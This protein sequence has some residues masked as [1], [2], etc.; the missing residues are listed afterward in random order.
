MTIRHSFLS[1]AL[2]LC[3]SSAWGQ[4]YVISTYAGNGTA[5]FTGDGGAPTSAQLNLPVGLTFDSSGNLYI[6]DGGNYRVR[7]IS[8]GSITTVAGNGTSGYSGDKAGATS[9]ELRDPT[10]LALDS[11]GNLYIADAPNHVIRMVTPG[12]TITTFAGNNTGG[13]AGDG[14][15]AT[16]AELE[17]PCGV[18]VDSSGNVWIADSGNNV[19]RVVTG[20]TI[21]TVAGGAATVAQLSN[22]EA[23]VFDAAGSLYIAD[24]G[25]RRILKFD[26]GELTVLAGGGNVGFAG[27][28][29]PAINAYLDDPMGVAVDSAGNVYVSDSINSRIRRIS[30][31]GIITTIAGSSD[32]GYSG[33]GGPA[34]NA[35]LQ[36]PRGIAVGS[37]GKIFI[38]DTGNNVVRALTPAAPVVNPNAVVNS[39]SFAPQISPGALAT[40]FGNGFAAAP[41]GASFPLLTNFAGVSVSVNGLAAPIL[42]VTPTQVNFQVPWETKV[43]S[44]TV[45]VNNGQASNSVVVPVLAAGPGL[46]ET[47]TGHAVV[48]NSDF[49]MNTSGNPAKEGTKVM[50]YLTG[51]GPVHPA[52]ADGAPAPANPTANATSSCTATIGTTTAEVSFAGLAPGFVGVMQVNILVPNNLG[53]GDYPLTV[54]VDGQ[55]SNTASIS[56]TP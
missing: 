53:P 31:S 20:G 44:A 50:A 19:I 45:V 13:Y 33:D 1:L 24:T 14:G 54:T 35:E 4:Q 16:S 41:A 18:A 29:G 40:L 27:D 34:P 11:S 8:G 12:G 2:G 39:A 32:P 5:G 22:P 51:S 15:A 55:D 47:S 46:F 9:A 30:P 52:L 17:F 37:S 10:G 42:F 23:I 36:F 3:L 28:N 56:V 25:S 48:L 38:A 43:G 21:V 7:K 6:S 49:K 26:H